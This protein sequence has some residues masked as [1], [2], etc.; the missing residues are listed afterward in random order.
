MAGKGYTVQVGVGKGWKKWPSNVK[1]S[2]AV[3]DGNVAL[4]TAWGIKARTRPL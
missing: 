3:A 2:K 1:L 4:L